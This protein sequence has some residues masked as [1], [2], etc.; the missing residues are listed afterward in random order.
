M[1]KFLIVI[2]LLT[3]PQF[4]LS[5]NN[6]PRQTKASERFNAYKQ[7]L[8]LQK[9]SLLKNVKLRS[10]G[11]SIMSGRVVDIDVSPADPSNFY[12][13]YASG[14][15]WVTKDNGISFK[16]LF[17]NQASITIGDIV[18]D[19]K[20][21]ETIWIGTGENNSSRSSYSGTGIYKS[22]NKGKTWEFVGLP[23]T[24]HIGRII[25]SP[26]NPNIVW[27]AAIG[28]LYSP[29][30]E[31]GVFKTTNGG[32]TW[33]QTLFIDENTGAID[34][35]IDP[36]NS[37]IL[38]A[39]M[40]YRTRRAWNFVGSGK[41]SAIYKSTDG[42][43]TWNLL[44]TKKSGF[45]TGQG[46]GRIGLSV[47]KNNPNIIYAVVD[48]QS[49]RPKKEEKEKPAV[50][51]ELLKNISV[52]DFLKL[53]EKDVNNFLD[54]NNFPKKYSAD[55]IFKM[56]KKGKIK[57]KALVDYLSDAN[58]ELFDT[59]VIGAEVYR[60]DDAGKTWKKTNKDFINNMFYTYGYYFGEIR[61][62]PNNDKNIYILGVPAL[63]S[64]DGGKT[65]KTIDGEN[66]HGD[67]HALW[68]D[69]NKDG[70]LIIGNDG[71]L[72]ISYD[73]GKH[74][75]K[76]NTPAVGQFYSVAVDN[77]KPY[78][79]YG[80]LQDNGVWYGPSTY[81][82]SYRWYSTGQYPYKFI[83]GGDGMQVSV[84]TTD[85]KT[86]YAGFQFGYYY[87]INKLT[88]K[89]IPIKPL[90]ELGE[91]SLRFNWQSPIY[92]SAHNP[93]IFYIGSNKL[94]RSLNKGKDYK[95]IS[96]DLTKG[97]KKGDVPFG[98]LTTIDE[99][100]LQFGLLYTGSDDGLIYVSKDGGVNWQNISNG[101]PKNL[102]VSRVTS[103]SH[104]LS[105]I[106]ISLNGYRWD[107]FYSYLYSS[108]D[109]GN[110]WKKIGMNLPAE[111][112]NVVKEDP[113][114]EDIIYVGT[115][116]GLYVSLNRGKSFMAL[117]NGM[118]AVPVHDLAIQKRDKDLVVGTHGRSIYIADIEHIENLTKNVLSS[119]VHLFP[120]KNKKFTD[121]WGNK[122]YAWGNVNEPQMKVTYY[123]KE[124]GVAEITIKTK[125]GLV[126]AQIQDTCDKGL[127]Y[128]NYDLSVDKDNVSEYKDVANTKRKK[129]E[130]KT[131]DNGKT[132]LHP[133]N[134]VIEIK[135]DDRISKQKFSI[136]TPR[137]R[138]R[139]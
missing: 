5:Q 35:S 103:S 25:L 68:L 59:P 133:G 93:D 126:L 82:P 43:E 127:N 37:K 53:N 86:V 119:I 97:G 111:P 70:H 94:Y 6:I 71:G 13:A 100:P 4:I 48:N 28:H 138:K 98:T 88:R 114:N 16:P 45:P 69:P 40:W 58:Q 9:K 42:G 8:D 129:V 30:K 122:F 1:K 55:I 78:N 75:F 95:A 84:D 46:V 139:G 66:V 65:F 51:K 79:V 34:L 63:I 90:P 101:L 128:Y 14:G 64:K 116:H 3:L 108:D 109:Y 23:E 80:G 137:K 11:P 12:V 73:N 81:V 27:V 76:A 135:I 96:F 57:P 47:Y 49:H 120:V 24:Q 20:H 60:S 112:I 18:V 99:S 33:K 134:Y 136:I 19:W 113:Y 22:N 87:R 74:W 61:V 41:T 102:W 85:N 10:V 32:K 77:A 123:T 17:D 130:F 2:I 117:F 89:T 38:Y 92:L 131:T 118:P 110:T 29:N 21:G 36:N 44:T 104:K 67:Y 26:N 15:L 105:R 52:S 107:D 31:R 62:N 83:L 125:K 115:D 7:R 121:K 56:I 54:A 39:A 124:K 132:Y 91:K 50:T 72:N 106:Y